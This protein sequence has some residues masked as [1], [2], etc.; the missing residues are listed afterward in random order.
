MDKNIRNVIHERFRS[1][2]D[3]IRHKGDGEKRSVICGRT[4]QNVE[5][6]CGECGQYVS[7]VLK[8]REVVEHEH[9]VIKIGEIEKERPCIQNKSNDTYQCIYVCLT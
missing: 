2:N 4:M 1:T 6:L 5:Y 8:K 9:V 7:Q 3:R